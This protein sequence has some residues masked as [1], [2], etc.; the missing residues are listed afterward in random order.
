MQ[1]E[2]EPGQGL[3]LSANLSSEAGWCGYGL[4]LTLACTLV[5][6]KCPGEGVVL[7]AI[8]RNLKLLPGQTP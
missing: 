4:G 6:G 1:A 2:W 7:L 3:F 8:L 5:A